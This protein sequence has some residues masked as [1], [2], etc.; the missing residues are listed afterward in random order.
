MI[1]SSFRGG[2]FH[3]KSSFDSGILFTDEDVRWDERVADYEKLL[4]FAGG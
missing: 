1:F 3:I 4:K 2:F